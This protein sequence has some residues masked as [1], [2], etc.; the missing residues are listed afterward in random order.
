MCK[1]MPVIPVDR[2]VDKKRIIGKMEGPRWRR[3]TRGCPPPKKKT[4]YVLAYALHNLPFLYRGTPTLA[5]MYITEMEIRQNP[6]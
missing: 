4:M 1:E 5:C 3:G 6:G 2:M